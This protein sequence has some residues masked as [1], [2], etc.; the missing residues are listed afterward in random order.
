MATS[1][2]R[3]ALTPTEWALWSAICIFEH[4]G[5]DWRGTPIMRDHIDLIDQINKRWETRRLDS[6][7]SSAAGARKR[8]SRDQRR[9]G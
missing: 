1:L 8:E 6:H 7:K 9:S 3:R 2:D 5:I 4:R